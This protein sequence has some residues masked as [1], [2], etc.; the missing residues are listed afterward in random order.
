[1]RIFFLQFLRIFEDFFGEGL[2]TKTICL[3]V[4]P[5]KSVSTSF[6]SI[7]NPCLSILTLFGVETQFLAIVGEIFK[8]QSDNLSVKGGGGGV[9][10]HSATFFRELKKT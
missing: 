6:W 5:V 1:M 7:L 10:L 3:I 8:G 4:Y 2:R 9:H